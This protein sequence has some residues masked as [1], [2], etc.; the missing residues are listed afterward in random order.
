MNETSKHHMR[1]LLG[2]DNPGDARLLELLLA[3]VPS[4]KVELV[5]V[6][7]LSEVMKILGEEQFDLILLDLSLP[8]SQGL[9]TFVQVQE[10]APAVPIIVLT[11][12]DDEATAVEIA[13]KGAQDYLVKGQVDGNL[14]VRAIRY[15]IER[16]RAEEALKSSE[17]RLTILFEAAPDAYYLVDRKGYIIEG[18]KAAEQLVGYQREEMVGKSFLKANVVPADQLVKAITILARSAIG[19]ATGVNELVLRRKDGSRVEVEVSGFPVRIEGRTLVLG[20]AR[21]I[22]ER[23]RAEEALRQHNRELALLNRAGQMFSSTLDLDQVLVTVL[24]EVRGLLGVTASSVW[25]LDTETRELVCQQATGPERESLLGTRLEWGAGLV[26]WV[27][28]NGKTLVVPDTQADNRHFKGVDRRT[29]VSIRSILS[30]PLQSKEGV[31]GVLQVLDAEADRLTESDLALV[32]PLAATAAIAIENARLYKELHRHAEMLEERVQERA[33]QLQVQ[34]AQSQAV[35][36]STADGIV[37]TDSEGE[38]R[39][40]N[41]VAKTWLTQ[42]FSPEDAERVRVAVRELAKCAADRPERVLELQGHDLELKA[43][44]IS[45]DGMGERAA[46]VAIHDISHLKAL[47]RMKSRFVTN[48]SHEL[49][50]PVTTIKLY[51]QLMQ[52]TSPEKWRPYVQSL[53]EEADHQAQLVEGILQISQIDSGRLELKPRPTELDELVEMTIGNHQVLATDRGVS[54]RHQ[55]P[56]EGPVALV[57]PRPLMQVLGNLV[58]NAIRYTMEGG[59]VTVSTATRSSNGREWATATVA[60]TGIGIP[61]LELPHVFE[62][63]FR[64]EGPRQISESGTGLGLAIAK[65]VVELHGGRL[66]AE[67]EVGVG[68]RFTVWLPLAAEEAQVGGN[69]AYAHQQAII[70]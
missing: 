7:R 41:P 36:R 61:A 4:A 14:L 45:G 31:I 63:F 11:G 34:Y 12:L 6:E 52:R 3:E 19:K 37:V 27:T 65:E 64:G 67:S 20:I 2:E 35:L 68:T 70:A 29:G 17:E 43:A 28:K 50:T 8:D 26:G 39:Q 58:G 23:K 66:E 15:A 33:S 40:A 49:R 47:D 16:K 1:I 13:R 5:H 9:D 56:G 53:A 51:A 18:N 42:D 32:E 22:T 25:L 69:G 48:V 10:R 60:D 30:V 59:T 21:D 38:I 55:D 44:P 46:V 54:L 57:D 62:R 24:E